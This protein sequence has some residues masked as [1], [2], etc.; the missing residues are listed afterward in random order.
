MAV[1]QRPLGRNPASRYLRRAERAAMFST[2]PVHKMG[3]VIIRNGNLIGGGWNKNH[4]HPRSR[5]YA[6]TIHAELAAIIMAGWW[7]GTL[8]ADLY[9]VRITKAGSMATSKPCSDCMDLIRD[10]GIKSVTY[11]SETGEVE[12]ERL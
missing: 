11:I 4:S 3:A 12:T 10:A 9:V 8:D 7:H 5:S 1:L 6:H 2:H